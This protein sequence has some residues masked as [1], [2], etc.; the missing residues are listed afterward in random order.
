MRSLNGWEI[1]L[2]EEEG[3]VNEDEEE[4]RG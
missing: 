3:D 4:D 2:E 1:S